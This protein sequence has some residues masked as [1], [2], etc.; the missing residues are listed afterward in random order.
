MKPTIRFHLAFVP[1][2][3][4]D[5]LP[6]GIIGQVE[7]IALV[8]DVVDTHGTLFARGCLDRTRAERVPAG[9]VK[10][11]W[12]HGDVLSQGMYDTDLHIGTVRSLEDRQLPDGRWVAWMKADILDTPKGEE[13][14]RYL[15]AVLAS[16]GETGLSVG[17]DPKKDET[18]KGTGG[19]MVQR[20]LEVALG[21]IS[22]TAMQSVPGTGALAV[23]SEP[24][25]AAL[26]PM[27]D[28]LL[29][30]LPEPQVRASI[31]AR[32]GNAAPTDT[33]AS[34]ATPAEDTDA[35][36]SDSHADAQPAIATMDERLRALRQ[37]YVTT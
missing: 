26:Q 21:E 24:D 12:D 14:H 16:G 7:G 34:T 5:G 20:F 17:I 1:E 2:L 11:F 33:D 31:D 8:Y 23:R 29:R 18:V 35:A 3:R 13:A 15:R 36:A 28:Y 6:P 19:K 27:L 22:I 30:T 32:F 4:A 25:P 9:K 10:L 37:T